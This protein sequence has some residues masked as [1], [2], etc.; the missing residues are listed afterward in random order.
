MPTYDRRRFVPRAIAQF[1]NQDYPSKELIIVDDGTD[2]IA[3]LVPDDPRIRLIRLPRRMSVGAKRN[4]ACENSA[5]EFIAHWDDDDWNAPHR[6]SC[7]AQRLL[8]SDASICGLKDLLFLDIRTTKAWEYNYP[9]NQRPWLSGNSLLYRKDYWSAHRFSDINVGEDSRF[10]WTA[11][12]HRLLAVA[13]AD[14]HVGLIHGTNVSPKHVDGPWWKPHP[15]DDIRRLL[16][17]DWN[18]I[19]ASDSVPNRVISRVAEVTTAALP[20]RN[21]FACLVHENPD[22]IL[23]LIRNLRHLD[24]TSVVLVYN[25]SANK[26]LLHALPLS[27]YGAVAHPSPQPMAWGKLHGFAIDCMRFGR[28]EFDF[29]TMTVVDSDQLALRPGYSAWLAKWLRDKPQVGMLGNA[30]ARQLPSTQVAP[31]MAAF[32]EID[33]WRPLLRRFKDGEAKFVHWSFWPS[34]VF[35]AAAAHDLVRFFDEDE[36]FQEIMTRSKI[37]ATEEVILPTLTALLGYEVAANPCSY[38]FVKYRVPYTPAQI[39]QSFERSDVFWAHP[40]PRRFDNVLRKE[41]RKQHGEYRGSLSGGVGAYP[42][43]LPLWAKPIDVVPLDP[44]LL[45][46]Q[47]ILAKMRAIE[48]WLEDEEAELLL[49]AAA[50]AIAEQPE[51]CAVVEVGSYC[52][53]ATVVLASVV[54]VLRPSAKVHAVDAHD[55]RVGTVDK[56]V[57]M[58]PSLPKLQRNLDAAGL[59]RYVEIIKSRTQDVSWSGLI[60]LLLIDGL[61][62][63]ASAS[64]DF[65]HFEDS[66]APGSLVAFHD[67]ADYFPGVMRFVGELVDSG[68][69]TCVQRVGTMVLLRRG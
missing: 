22:C 59:S 40:I 7:Q 65:R 5:G 58:A 38:D 60:A 34:T 42:Q 47:P 16:G 4:I 67:Y 21:V 23:D 13:D 44:P 37:W 48:G 39:K 31:A 36:Q 35:S 41:I 57:Q 11:D 49:A 66:L 30:P 52:G 50:R 14:F 69:Y 24:P 20:L 15:L 32:T 53:K 29:Q 62:D 10:V 33:L 61:H 17:D 46:T 63:Y 56:I 12:A 51:S 28:E 9:A 25:G 27:Q 2:P 18:S 64:G 8:N 19:V 43:A 68:K 54:Q 3:D 1:Q 6:L 55:G 45:L 26:H